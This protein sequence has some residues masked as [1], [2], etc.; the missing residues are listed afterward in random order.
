MFT[1]EVAVVVERA[2]SI[3]TDVE[4]GEACAIEA[5]FNVAIGFVEGEAA[6][7]VVEAAVLVGRVGENENRGQ[8]SKKEGRAET[9]GE[10]EH[11]VRTD[12]ETASLGCWVGNGLGTRDMRKERGTG[13]GWRER[14][15]WMCW[16]LSVV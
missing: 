1:H 6:M 14:T 3:S 5:L 2:A 4:V 11:G 9:T 13:G 15:W 10:G 7:G 16:G 8:S 12:E